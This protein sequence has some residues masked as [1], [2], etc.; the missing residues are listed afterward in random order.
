MEE[1]C[2]QPNSESNFDVFADFNGR[3]TVELNMVSLTWLC[4]KYTVSLAAGSLII[5]SF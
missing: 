4:M 1:A 5:S 3:T 2:D